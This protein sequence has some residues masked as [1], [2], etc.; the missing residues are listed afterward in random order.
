MT[1]ETDNSGMCS[2]DVGGTALTRTPGGTPRTSVSPREDLAILPTHPPTP[3]APSTGRGI[4][5]RVAVLPTSHRIPSP[6][7]SV[8]RA[9]SGPLVPSA[10]TLPR[11]LP[12]P[13]PTTNPLLHPGPRTIMATAATMVV[14]VTTTGVLVSRAVTAS[15]VMFPLA[16]GISPPA[17]SLGCLAVNTS[18][19]IPSSTSTTAVV[20]PL[21]VMVRT[22]TPSLAF[23]TLDAS[24]V[25]A[26][27]SFLL[28]DC[29][30][31]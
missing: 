20:V 15:L 1:V 23:G 8:T 6:L 4:L 17:L 30:R 18:V 29:R 27:V 14:V 11:L 16:L 31:I 7:L 26:R 10:A 12:Q 21:S 25:L 13:L 28:L 9:G 24:K 3:T 19:L 2:P 22:A 5:E